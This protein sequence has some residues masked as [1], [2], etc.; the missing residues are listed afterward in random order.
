MMWRVNTD[1]ASY[2]VKQL[3]PDID[4]TNK[5]II[6]NYNFTEEIA[7]RFA[8]L[9]I[10]AISA[11]KQAGKYL[12][13]IDGTGFLIYPWTNAQPLHHDAVSEDHAVE[14]AKILA[15][16]HHINLDV[17]EIAEPE[18]DVHSTET[19]IQLIQKA[20]NYNC[21]FAA[22]LTALQQDIL[23]INT[24]YQNTLPQLKQ[25][26]VVSHGD[27]DQKN[28]LWDEKGSPIVIDWECTRKLNPTY[29]I[30]NACLDWSGITTHFNR[31]LFVKMMQAYSTAGGSLDKGLLEAAF[32]AVLGNWINWMVYNIKRACIEQDCEQKTLGIE[33]VNQ[34]LKTITNLNNIVPK[35][36][37]YIFK[38]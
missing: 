2:A 36:I 14:I 3:S 37:T 10:P 16:M 35:L 34:V 9:G 13:L 4:L 26:I 32:N 23:A 30:V 12:K 28:V 29:E 22:N 18:F 24:A 11:M 38:T 31:S 33:Q 15:K 8:Q 25:H 7:Y 20:N 17:P 21:P 6:K 5:A 27:L 1:E 19:L